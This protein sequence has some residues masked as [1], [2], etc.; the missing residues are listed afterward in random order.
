MIGQPHFE[1][2]KDGALLANAGHFDVEIDIP[3]LRRMAREERLR[4]GIMGYTMADG[5]TLCLLAEGRL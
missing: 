1:V 5:R 2:M 4:P 3:A